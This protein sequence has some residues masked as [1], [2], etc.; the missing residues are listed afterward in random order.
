M[1]GLDTSTFATEGRAAADDYAAPTPAELASRFPDL[2]I[3]EPLGRG[4]MGVVYKARQK[5]LDRLIALK[6]LSPKIARDPAFAERFVREARAMAKLNH[7]HIVAV[8]DFGQMPPGERGT[9]ASTSSSSAEMKTG[10]ED[11]LYYFLMELVDGVT[12]RRLLDTGKLAPEEALAIVPQICEALQYAHDAGVVHRDIKP[13]NI[14]LGKN[15]QVK[16][17]DFGLAKLIGRA[18]AA[19]A[20]AFPAASN[21]TSKGEDFQG[22]SPSR[23]RGAEGDGIACESGFANAAPWD[24]AQNA[25]LPRPN[26]DDAC[27]AREAPLPAPQLTAAGQVMGT[28]Q[29]MAP[30][31]VANPQSVDHRADIYSLGV[32]FYQMLTGELPVGRFAPPSKKVEIDVRLDEVVL[33]AL[34]QEPER[35]YQQAGEIKTRVE[36]IA[37]TP[38]RCE[39]GSVA[40]FADSASVFS[41]NATRSPNTSRPNT[42]EAPA[43]PTDRVSGIGPRFSRTAIV[44]AAWASLSFVLFALFC[45][46]LQVVPAGQ[47][48]GP[49]WWQI[50]LR[51]TVLPLGLLAPFG[52]TLLGVIAL[53]QIRHA[54]GRLCGLG[55]ALFDALLFPLLMLDGLIVCS[56]YGICREWLGAIR[57]IE[58]TEGLGEVVSSTTGVMLPWVVLILA[59][60]LAIVVDF[61]IVRWAWRSAN[62]PMGGDSTPTEPSLA[63]APPPVVFSSAEVDAI[64]QARQQVNAPAIGLLVMGIL[65]LLAIP[66][67]FAAFLWVGPQ[68]V[69][70]FF[71]PILLLFS[72]PGLFVGV[73]TMAAAV[74]MKRL[75]GYGIAVAASILTILWIGPIG[76]AIGVWSL[77]VLCRPAVGKAF[78]QL[79]RTKPLTPAPTGFQRTV[80]VASLVLFAAAIPAALLLGRLAGGPWRLV[81]L[82]CL[83]IELAAFLLGL[84]GRRHWAGRVAAFGSGGLLVLALTLLTVVLLA[85]IRRDFG[86]WPSIARLM[87]DPANEP[88]GPMLL[89]GTD[90]PTTPFPTRDAIVRVLGQRFSRTGERPLAY[91]WLLADGRF[92]VIVLG[93]SDADRQ[94]VERLVASP[95]TLELRILADARRDKAIVAQAMKDASKSEICDPAGKKLA[96]WVPVDSTV[97]K[98]LP[99]NSTIV[100]R[101]RKTAGHDI[102]EALVMA[103]RYNVTGKHLN[104]ARAVTDSREMTQ[105]Q[106]TF[107]EEGGML[108][109]KLTGENLPDDASGVH[110][111]LGV[112]IDGTLCSSPRI[113]SV[114]ST[115]CELRGFTKQYAQDASDWARI[116][117][118]GPLPVPLRLLQTIPHSMPIS[119][120]QELLSRYVEARVDVR[121]HPAGP[122]IAKLPQGE[123][124][125]VA[126]AR[127]PSKDQPWWLP[128]GTSYS[129]PSFDNSGQRFTVANKAMDHREFVFRVPQNT[130]LEFRQCAPNGASGGYGMPSREG[131]VLYEYRT[132]PAAFPASAQTGTLQVAAAMGDWTTV[133]T[134]SPASGVFSTT[135]PR[136]GAAD[137]M[138]LFAAAIE[139]AD[140]SVVASVSY[141]KVEWE[142]RLIAVDEKDQEHNA[143]RTQG[144]VVN[145]TRQ[146]T[147]TFD[148]LPIKRIKEFRF[149]IRPY[150][151][152]EFRDVSLHPGKKVAGP[153]GA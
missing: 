52:A 14:L 29:Y 139:K 91:V 135:R 103:D 50:G 92:G 124:E 147:A 33:R 107:S 11:T 69:G 125:L 45:M 114:L 129:G 60:M 75:E 30:E 108:L 64:E 12:L 70:E 66:L 119:D 106:L 127:H 6:I 136:V 27:A 57:R 58:V 141:P 25:S 84:L 90:S 131:R 95:G 80:G 62:R 1:R 43:L 140:G 10:G 101:V 83:A 71:V 42:S 8:Y 81:F 79:K 13:E 59:A 149:Q 56:P 126:I 144:G 2:E 34:E 74:R 87:A 89:Y 51:F 44:G 49:E 153:G 3:L 109:A 61:F 35:R 145:D 110:P 118:A 47:Y 36:T 128:D 100:C 99:A 54:A 88:Q 16:I 102:D 20:Q 46:H 113:H 40:R 82:T 117:N 37:T 21:D 17:A 78:A 151:L 4:G 152:I 116:V 9:G 146:L 105:M 133:E 97:R 53:S 130:T 76:L 32:V 72:G 111:A 23:E 18:A 77:V 31:Q 5:Q 120:Q 132:L 24:G 22:S 55:L 26:T 94:H 115:R 142:T 121:E 68:T 38:Q 19:T 143:S 96:W 112:I 122:W 86:G 65:E 39:N 134:H 150:H 7:P 85:T 28:P 93:A 63:A 73:F 67:A 137:W 41:P 15:G 148:N 138:V 123:I 48:T 104:T 98:A